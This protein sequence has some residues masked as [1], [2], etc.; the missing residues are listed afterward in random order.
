MSDLTKNKKKENKE[1]VAT[2]KNTT[3]A[4]KTTTSDPKKEKPTKE[5]KVIPKRAAG[6]DLEPI[7]KKQKAMLDI[8]NSVDLLSGEQQEQFLLAIAYGLV[9]DKFGIEAG[10]D[11][12]LKAFEQFQK[13]QQAKRLNEQSQDS[14]DN[15]VTIIDDIS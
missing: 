3:A 15:E 5:K 14:D 8:I 11:T 13:L 2:K 4:K 6:N 7:K 12:R 1:S 10:L 9:P